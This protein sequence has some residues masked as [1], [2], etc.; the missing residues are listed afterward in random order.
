M[1]KE[2]IYAVYVKEGSSFKKVAEYY[3]KPLAEIFIRECGDITAHIV[4][5]M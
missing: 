5:E 4:E 3:H 1:I 2:T